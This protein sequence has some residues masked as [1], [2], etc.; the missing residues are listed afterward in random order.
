MRR[1][2][3]RW[4]LAQHLPQQPLG[5]EGSSHETP[6]RKPTYPCNTPPPHHSTPSGGSWIRGL[7]PPSLLIL[8]SLGRIF[9]QKPTPVSKK[10]KKIWIKFFLTILCW[11]RKITRLI[12]NIAT[13]KEEY[14]FSKNSKVIPPCYIESL[15]KE[16]RKITHSG[17]I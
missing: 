13:Q 11:K 1:L 8:L 3:C 6:G 9:K 10:K 4:G 17:E 7:P 15:Q 16:K 12:K 2:E 5:P 14:H